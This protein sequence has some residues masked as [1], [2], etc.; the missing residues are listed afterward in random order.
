VFLSSLRIN[1]SFVLAIAAGLFKVVFT[2]NSL[3]QLMTDRREV[4]GTVFFFLYVAFLTA[5]SFM[6]PAPERQISRRCPRKPVRSMILPIPPLL[7]PV[8][9][10][11][12]KPR[13]L[14]L[15]VQQRN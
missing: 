13:V 1:S 5:R 3:S 12:R 11:F 8:S 6:G 10:F 14:S 9:F 4:A 15:M 2:F 7:C